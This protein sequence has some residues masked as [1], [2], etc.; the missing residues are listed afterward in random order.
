MN[1][2]PTPSTHA[3]P[4]T[5]NTAGK[6]ALGTVEDAIKLYIEKRELL[7]KMD[8]EHEKAKEPHIALQNKLTGWLQNFMETNKCDS[9]KTAEGTC[10]I[11][12]K[13]TASLADP[14]IFMAFVK[15]TDSFDLL[16]RKAN[17]TAV[18]AY[19]EEHKTLPPGVNL[20]AFQACGV[21]RASAS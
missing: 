13:Y 21:R 19:V 6:P 10:Y 2:H 8:A 18:K 17:V 3:T 16:D 12:T 4:S 5:S 9:L 20:S 7:A 1:N 14:E 11:K 15:S